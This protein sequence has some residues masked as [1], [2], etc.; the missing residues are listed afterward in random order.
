MVTR[1]NAAKVLRAARRDPSARRFMIPRSRPV[2]PGEVLVKEFLEPLERTQ[3]WLAS[4]TG[5]PRSA[6]NLIV[7]G[8]RGIT[9][10]TA[11]KLAKVLGTSPQFWMGLQM[12]VDLWDARERAEGAA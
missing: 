3:V 11:L 9:A 4:E 6:L 5:V 1:R 10:D 2:T 7:K 12:A 8:K